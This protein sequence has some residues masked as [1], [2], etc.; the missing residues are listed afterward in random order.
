MKKLLF[1]HNKL[2]IITFVLFFTFLCKS[3][4]VEITSS[5]NRTKLGVTEQLTYTLT[6]KSSADIGQPQIVR[7]DFENF[8]LL[9]QSGP[10]TKQSITITQ[11]VRQ[12]TFERTFTFI[13]LPKSIGSFEIK[14]AYMIVNGQRYNTDSHTITVVDKPIETPDYFIK[15]EL[16]KEQAYIDEIII[17]RVKLYY[18]KGIDRIEMLEM[19]SFSNFISENLIQSRDDINYHTQ[20]YNGVNYNVQDIARLALFPLRSG[21]YTISPPT[22]R[23]IIGDGFFRRQQS[24][25]LRDNKPL[26]IEVLRPPA[27]NRPENFSGSV[28]N[29][30]IAMNVDN[31][32]ENIRIGEAIN[33][34]ISIFGEGNLRSIRQPDLVNTEWL[35]IYE[36]TI[37]EKQDIESD[38]IYFEKKFSYIMV[39]IRK[40]EFSLGPFEYVYFNPASNDYKTVSTKKYNFNVE[41]GDEEIIEQLTFASDRNQFQEGFHLQESLRFIKSDLSTIKNYNYFIKSKLFNIAISSTI[42]VYLFYLISIKYYLIKSKNSV[43]IRRKK[44]LKTANKVL[45]KSLEYLNAKK[46]NDFALEISKAIYTYTGDKFNLPASGLTTE[47]I[48]ELLEKQNVPQTLI[49]EIITLIEKCDLIRFSSSSFS[50]EKLSDIYEIAIKTIID[51]EKYLNN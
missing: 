28:G 12:Q 39:P 2:Y 35:N 24:H 9:R 4:S 36:P 51:V 45:K 25:V 47:K 13:L 18:L 19:P 40:G 1:Y 31:Y 3:Y 43:I 33:V 29:I 46:F 37:T 15:A 30:E 8:S 38:K 17:Y 48:K 50:E 5:V 34:K 42:L 7:P 16:S 23:A 6:I 11:G 21:E 14:P 22:A 26:T 41:E 10:S 44:A 49:A 20:V 27:E 32:K